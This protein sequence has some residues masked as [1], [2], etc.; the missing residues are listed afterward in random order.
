MPPQYAKNRPLFCF[1]FALASPT[2]KFVQQNERNSY[3]LP[4]SIANSAV[5]FFGVSEC[6]SP[7]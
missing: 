7:N 5:N 4:C 2:Y 3:A 1:A 6:G